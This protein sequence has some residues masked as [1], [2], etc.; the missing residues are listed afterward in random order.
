MATTESGQRAALV[1]R[2]LATVID[3]ELGL[4]IVKLGLV[5]GVDVRDDIARITYTL[6]TRGCPIERI[7]TEAIRAAAMLVE[8]VRHVETTIVW[9]PAWHAGMIAPDAFE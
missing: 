7:L 4:D 3:P 1:W 2:T 9:Q 8:G 6:T 5:Y